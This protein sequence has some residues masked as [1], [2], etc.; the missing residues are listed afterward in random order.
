MTPPQI[1]SFPLIP[2][3]SAVRIRNKILVIS[4]KNKQK[5]KPLKKEKSYS[6]LSFFFFYFTCAKVV[7]VNN[8]TLHTKM[9]SLP[10]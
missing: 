3:Q 6:R 1:G 5:K 4:H 8:V 2:Q 7:V 10:H 9:K